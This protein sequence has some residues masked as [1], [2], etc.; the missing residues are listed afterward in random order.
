MQTKTNYAF[1]EE[2]SVPFNTECKKHC[3]YIN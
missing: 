2:K 3:D 1:R